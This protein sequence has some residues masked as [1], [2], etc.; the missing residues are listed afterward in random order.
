MAATQLKLY[1][2]ALRIC[3]H[4]KIADLTVN[5]EARHLLDDAWAAGKGAIN[6]CLRKGLWNF[7]MREVKVEYTSDFTPGFGYRYPFNKPSDW[8]RT[9]QISADEYFS[10]PLTE[11]QDQRDFWFADVEPLYV[12]YV[13]DD[14]EY[15]SDLS[16]WPEGFA[17]YF[18]TY[19]AS[20][21]IHKLSAATTKAEDVMKLAKDRLGTAKSLDAMDEATKFLPP[22]NWRQSRRGRRSG[23]QPRSTTL[24]H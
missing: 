3:G 6:R 9:A 17:E 15:G 21:I 13:S 12:R 11:V 2:A 10:L 1:N 22:G 4:S 7:A 18:E 8:V 5:E 23:R 14:N 24:G 16:L 20:E 19:L